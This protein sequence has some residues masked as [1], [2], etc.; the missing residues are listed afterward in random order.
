[1]RGY[2]I[3]L[4][5]EEQVLL[6]AIDLR[7]THADHD[8]GRAAHL[9]NRQPVLA[10]LQSLDER[11]AIPDERLNY[12]LE[13]EY[14]TGRHKTS[15]KGMFERNGC[16]GEDIYIH[17]H[18]LPYFRYFLFGVDLPEE[19]VER[20]EERVDECI[21]VTSSDIIP[22]AKCART[23]TRR[24]GLE[25]RTA[26]EEFFKLCLDMELGLSTADHVRRLVMQV[27]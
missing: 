25:G 11:E 26:S 17:P 2:E 8:E 5:P 19:V 23:L 21:W 7:D 24:F 20:F 4:T 6:N 10:L 9:A 12:W 15:H 16:T 3:D 18:F 1:M 13:P 22:I 27:R 14:Y